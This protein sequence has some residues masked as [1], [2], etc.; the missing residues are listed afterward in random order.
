M[1]VDIRVPPLGESLVAATVGQWL[2]REG[3]P[4]TAGEPLVELETEKVNLEVSAEAT[5]VLERIARGPGSNVHAGEVLGSL[6][7]EVATAPA[8]S[9]A[10]TAPGPAVMATPPPAET[11]HPITPVARQMAA[12]HD[13]DL[14][15]VTGS[16][17]GGRIVQAD[18]SRYLDEHQPAA[19]APA[20]AMIRLPWAIA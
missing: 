14:A 18:I 20:P 2:K 8:P 5:G 12:E 13:I 7:T 16:G 11:P 4:V 9:T 6:A 15:A 19:A 10:E 1:A 3:D 17:P